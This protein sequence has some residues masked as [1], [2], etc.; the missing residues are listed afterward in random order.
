MGVFVA[1]ALS[2]S[3]QINVLSDGYSVETYYVHDSDELGSGMDTEIGGIAWGSDNKMY[4]T[5]SMWG[6]LGGGF[7]RYDGSD[8]ECLTL[9]YNDFP[10]ATV[11]GV[12][13]KIF[14]GSSSWTNVQSIH[15]F[16]TA[17]DT[18]TK[19]TAVNYSLA[20]YS[21]S[22]LIQG[23]SD[24]NIGSPNGVLY[25]FEG[26]E[27]SVLLATTPGASGGIYA[28]PSGLFVAPGAGDMSVYR[29]S[30][31]ELNYAIANSFLMESSEIRLWVDYSSM[32]AF[33]GF[34]GA[35]SLIEHDGWLYITFTDFSSGSVLGA[36]NIAADGSFGGVSLE[37]LEYEGR[38]SELGVHDGNLYIAAGDTVYWIHTPA[39][40]EP[41]TWAL[42]FGG[43]TVL[44]ILR[45]KQ[46]RSAAKL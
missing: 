32:P 18:L 40:P 1:G 7:Y 4:Y 21:D 13:D 43:C 30:L 10:G 34:A 38:L 46:S 29:W 9:A 14:F 17:N 33:S 22:L 41:T 5:T 16:D 23:T 2:A 6:Y 44:V 31:T 45:K 11:V 26:T 12:G 24:G 28:G 42:L 25:S 15:M 36:F 8:G 35:T 3:A 19:R 27:P 39:V 37:V 20:S